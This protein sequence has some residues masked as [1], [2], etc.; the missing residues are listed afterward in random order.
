MDAVSTNQTTGDLTGYAWSPNIGWLKFGGLSDFPSGGGVQSNAKINLDSGEITGWIRA[1]AGTV[2]GET[3]TTGATCAS[4]TSRTDG[5][6]GW[7]E[8]SGQ[9][10]TSLASALQNKFWDRWFVNAQATNRM[11]GLRMDVKTGIVSGMAWG[12]PVVGWL[13]FNAGTSSIAVQFG[14]T[15]SSLKLSNT[16][17]RF[18]ALASGG[19]G[20]YEYA[21]NGSGIYGNLSS[22]DKVYSGT[23]NSTSIFYL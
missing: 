4:M 19:T 9:N 17:I 7:I 5:W 1:C 12:G 6:D 21:W 22:F 16:K 23:G 2:G 14:S 3:N 11:E 10:H 8:L 20:S 15:C 13:N 18:T